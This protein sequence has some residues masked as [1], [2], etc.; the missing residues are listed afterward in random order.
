MDCDS[1]THDATSSDTTETRSTGVLVILRNIAYDG[2]RMDRTSLADFRLAQ[3]NNSGTKATVWANSNRTV[4]NDL[5]SDLAGRM[6]VSIRVNVG[7]RMEFHD[8]SHS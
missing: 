8:D 3:N 2:V 4:N 7:R 5:W 1:F 6:D